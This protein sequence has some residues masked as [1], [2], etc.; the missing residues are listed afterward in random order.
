M[1]PL[2]PTVPRIAL[3]DM[4]EVRWLSE[5]EQLAWRAFQEMQARLSAAL[6]RDLASHSKLSYPD[7]VVLVVLTD[8]PGG[9]LRLQELARQLGWE[10]SRT[11]HQVSRMLVRGLVE[12]Y[13]CGEDQRGALV[14]AS[15]QGWREIE[16][17]APSHVEAV[18]RLVVDRLGAGELER[19]RAIS[20]AVLEAVV[21]EE[22]HRPGGSEG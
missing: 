20:S 15:E 18:R 16:K 19:L 1:Y 12:K 9:Q 6:A 3:S 10:K 21:E 4:P 17:A 13:A 5:G 11:S 8:R 22:R 14:V 7:Y 2:F